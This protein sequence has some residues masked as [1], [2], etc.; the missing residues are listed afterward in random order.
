MGFLVPLYLAGLAA[1]SLP[2]IFHLVRRAPRG[3]QDFSSLMFLAPTPP[4]LTRRSR[5]DQLLL[6]AMR[7]L[8]LA[9]LAFAFARP[10]LR[11]AAALTPEGLAG[12][13]VAIL[14]DTSASMKRGDLWQQALRHVEHELDQLNPQDDVAL[15]SFDDSLTTV[16]DFER[17]HDAP[18]AGKPQVARQ[19]LAFMKPSWRWTDLGSAL[20]AVAG[21]LDAATDAKQSSLEPQIVVVSDFQRGSRIE[22]LQAFEWPKRIPVVL[23][24]VTPIRKT[25]AFAHV[26]PAEEEGE[27]D[28]ANVRVRVVNAAD[29]TSEQFYV[30][31]AVAANDAR[32]PNETAVFV[33]AGQSRVIR[34]PRAAENATADHIVL[35]G[36]DHDF[37][38]TFSIV[39]LHRQEVTVVY[40]GADGA[41][42]R[43]GMLHFL[44]LAVANDPLRQV[45]V[46]NLNAGGP[47]A[48]ATPTPQL[49]IVA[50]PVSSDQ[51][52]R[53]RSSV[54]GGGTLLLVPA[55]DEAARSLP[56]FFEDVSL[57]AREPA[58]ESQYLLLG[59]IDFSHPLF[60]PFASPRYSDF[61]RIHFWK[62]RRVVLK[63]PANTRVI[64]RF[65]NGDPAVLERRLGTGRMI[66]LTSGW[67][68]D[69]SQL[70]LSSKFV[71]LIGALL[72]LA[73]GTVAMPASVAVGAS[74]PISDAATNS[75]MIVRAPDGRDI[76]LPAGTTTFGETDQPGIY[77]VAGGPTDWRFAV[78]LS[79]AESD[80]APLDVEHLEQRGVRLG[81]SLTR[82]ER[83]DRVRQQRDTELESRQKVWHWL[84]AASLCV[85]AVET[86]WAGRTERM[87]VKVTESAS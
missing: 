8:A 56:S 9:L 21:E 71:P 38:N 23:R 58:G 48:S 53:L 49:V 40:A 14:V 86:W 13:R 78:N 67:Q 33:P 55:D 34:L 63:E 75:S 39:P 18:T 65:D 46:Q 57:A 22:A 5:L 44:R 69:E 2:F 80:T 17:E 52:A 87:I 3:R 61:T 83:V 77:H 11:E 27:Y 41:D 36:D 37:D 10:F 16:V 47:L 72:D 66:A 4:R 19:R 73:C 1:L 43:R 30:S 59:E 64:A 54:E 68:P 42:D 76:A 81:P 32:R 84:I 62:H 51:H 24:A 85:L 31:W 15:F 50:Q 60:A 6:L 28:P 45:A 35:R 29:S 25:N 82:A 74:V 20:V 79:A 12:R 26:L 70:A 7:L